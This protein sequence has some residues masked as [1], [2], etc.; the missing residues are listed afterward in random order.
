MLRGL[1][2]LVVALAVVWAAVRLGLLVGVTDQ[3]LTPGLFRRHQ[4][5]Q[6]ALGET[7][8][9]HHDW[10]VLHALAAREVPDAR[11]ALLRQSALQRIR[12]RH[13]D[14]TAPTRPACTALVAAATLLQAGTLDPDAQARIAQA[15]ETARQEINLLLGA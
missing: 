6:R 4:L 10:Q 11:A 15:L 1:S 12:E 9:L 8:Q 5:L 7:H 14:C 13:R 3:V 2:Y